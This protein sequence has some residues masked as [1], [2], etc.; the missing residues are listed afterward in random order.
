MLY[1]RDASWAAQTYVFLLFHGL[2]V[3]RS[4]RCMHCSRCT[5]HRTLAATTSICYIAHFLWK[6]FFNLKKIVHNLEGANFV[7]GA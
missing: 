7:L 4:D 5:V 2:L 3:F 1:S 6:F